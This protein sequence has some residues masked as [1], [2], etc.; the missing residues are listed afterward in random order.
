MKRIFVLAVAFASALLAAPRNSGR[1]SSSAS[2]VTDKFN[3]AYNAHDLEGVMS[4]FTPDSE[5]MQFPDKIVAKGTEE[6]RKRYAARLAEPNLH[7][8]VTNRITVGDKVIDHERIVR[9]FPEGPGV[10]NIVTIIEVQ[11]GHIARFWF[12]D[13]GKTLTTSV[14]EKEKP[15]P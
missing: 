9:T 8:A 15:D 2:D 11:N 12:I 5:F 1:E 7:A 6:I 10:W 14:S 13:G 3:A 4:F